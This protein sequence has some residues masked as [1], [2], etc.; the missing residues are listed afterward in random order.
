M[1]EKVV[2]QDG[3]NDPP[4]RWI[5]VTLSLRVFGHKV[6]LHGKTG[7]TWYIGHHRYYSVRF[8]AMQMIVYLLRFAYDTGFLSSSTPIWVLYEEIGNICLNNAQELREYSERKVVRDESD[9]DD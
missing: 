2:V 7:S 5:G 8:L 3:D 9:G 4:S 6:R 1:A